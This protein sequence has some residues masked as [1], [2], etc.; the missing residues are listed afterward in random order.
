MAV[1]DANLTIGQTKVDIAEELG[2]SGLGMQEGFINELLSSNAK[3]IKDP[4]LNEVQSA[5]Q[6]NDVLVYASPDSETGKKLLS[7]AGNIHQWK[8]G[9]TS[10][11]FVI[12]SYSIHYT[13][14]YEM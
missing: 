1:P 5:I 11:Q 12:T 14:L 8:E 10:H 6:N 7:L 9:L 4:S 3:V 2:I 13:K